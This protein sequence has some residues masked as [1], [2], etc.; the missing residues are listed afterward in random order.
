MDLFFFWRR[1]Y[2]NKEAINTVVL[3][4]NEGELIAGDQSGNIKIYDL[5]AD[6]C[7]AKLAAAPDI[8]IRSLSMAVNTFCLV[9]ADSAGFC[10]VWSLKNG[11]ELIPFQ[12]K[13]QAH[14]DYILKCTLSPD[15]K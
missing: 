15:V 7:R 3:H 1:N 13:F 5:V 10:H 14:E 11:E 8:G 2:T 9:A 6:K 4:P 12:Q